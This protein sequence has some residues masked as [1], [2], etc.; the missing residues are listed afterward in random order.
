MTTPKRKE[1]AAGRQIQL[2]KAARMMLRASHENQISYQER[3]FSR[4]G[5]PVPF[6][7]FLVF[8]NFIDIHRIRQ[9]RCSCEE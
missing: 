4:S 1:D 6:F 9:W 7:Y 8:F 3:R 5:I 2:Y